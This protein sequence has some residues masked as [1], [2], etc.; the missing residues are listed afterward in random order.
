MEEAAKTEYPD[1]RWG[2]Q[3]W[4]HRSMLNVP[5]LRRGE[6]IGLLVLFR[7]EVKPFSQEQIALVEAFADQAVIA[8]ENARL[9]DELEQRNCDLNEALEQQTATAQVLETI[10]RA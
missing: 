9:F 5:L 10:S 4:G 6:P 3:Q 7:F 2:Q 8:I 1:S